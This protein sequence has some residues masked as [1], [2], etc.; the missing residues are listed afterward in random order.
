M[1]VGIAAGTYF[2]ICA[3]GTDIQVLNLKPSGPNAASSKYCVVMNAKPL[4]HLVLWKGVWLCAQWTTMTFLIKYSVENLMLT[5]TVYNGLASFTPCQAIFIKIMDCVLKKKRIGMHVHWQ[6]SSQEVLH[7]GILKK[8]K[9]SLKRSCAL[10]HFG[11]VE[12]LRL[13]W[14]I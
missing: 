11:L 10:I 9:Y 6:L 13:Q 2:N 4:N 8:R 5:C 7:L 1:S 14:T 3:E 12:S